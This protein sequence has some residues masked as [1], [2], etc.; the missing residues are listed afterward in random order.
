MFS[1]SKFCPNLFYFKANN[2][3]FGDKAIYECNKG[4]LLAEENVCC[5]TCQSDGTFSNES[6]T[7]VRQAC[8]LLPIVKH[9]SFL[10]K[11]YWFGDT[12]KLVCEEGSVF[13]TFF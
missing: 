8:N 4:Y 1:I 3:V 7:C 13:F 12:A 9:G 10:T 5:R 6:I 2:H 11:N